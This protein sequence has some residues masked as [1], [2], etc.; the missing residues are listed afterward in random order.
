MLGQSGSACAGCP[1]SVY[2]MSHTHPQ[3][4]N[5]HPQSIQNSPPESRQ[6]HCDNS[7]ILLS[8]AWD[9]HT[10]SVPYN[11]N[12][13]KKYLVY[14]FVNVH[15]FIIYDGDMMEILACPFH[16]HTVSIG[17]SCGYMSNIHCIP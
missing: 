14:F 8:C 7:N 13:Y 6:Y 10:L 15:T 5:S 11:F 4:T 2:L 17:Y 3:N 16:T 12:M 1:A 9:M